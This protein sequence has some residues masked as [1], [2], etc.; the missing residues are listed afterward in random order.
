MLLVQ[1]MNHIEQ[2]YITVFVS[3][4]YRHFAKCQI[5]AIF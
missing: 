5:I 1:A 4:A 2:R 3:V